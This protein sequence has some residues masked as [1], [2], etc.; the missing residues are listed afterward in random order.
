[1]DTQN[2]L[3]G[4]LRNPY[5]ER[6]SFGFQ[7]EL[8]AHLFLDVSYIGSESHRL[9][10]RADWNPRLPTGLRLYPQYG[11]VIAKTSEGNSSYNALQALFSRRFK[12]G[13]QFSAAYTWSKMID[14]TSDGVG[15][16]ND[17]GST[18]TGIS[19]RCR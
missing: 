10:T 11:Q 15:N 6:W 17:A 1:M 3:A 18:R 7:R 8:P 9:I 12:Q 16:V 2:P 4:N 5:T 19:R 13:F 14:S